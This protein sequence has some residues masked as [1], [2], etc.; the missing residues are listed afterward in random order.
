MADYLIALVADA[1][2]IRRIVTVSTTRRTPTVWQM[3]R[4][5]ALSGKGSHPLPEQAEAPHLSNPA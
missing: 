3:V 2:A 5:E 1:T 4:Q